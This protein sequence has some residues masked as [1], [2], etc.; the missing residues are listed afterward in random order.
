MRVG[1]WSDGIS[2]LVK[3]DAREL[4]LPL[5]LLPGNTIYIHIHIYT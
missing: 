2:A 3:G 4:E 5:A 1:L